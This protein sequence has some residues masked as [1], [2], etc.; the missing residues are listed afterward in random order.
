MSVMK[1]SE[2]SPSRVVILPRTPLTKCRSVEVDGIKL[3]HYV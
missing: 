3:D 1:L 2:F